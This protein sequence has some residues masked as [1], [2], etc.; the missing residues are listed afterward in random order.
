MKYEG[1][2]KKDALG[3]DESDILKPTLSQSPW[4][5]SRSKAKLG[6]IEEEK[7]TPKKEN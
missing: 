2:E 4:I 7:Q 1:E 3:Q 6:K 5:P